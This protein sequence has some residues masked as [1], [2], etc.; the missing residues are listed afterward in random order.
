MIILGAGAAG[1]FAGAHSSVKTLILEKKNIAGN[2]LLIA[3]QGRCNFTHSGYVSAFFSHYGQNENFIKQV[4]KKYT[5]QD[6]ILFFEKKGLLITEDKNGKLFPESGN[7]RDILNI[8][9]TECKKKGNNIHFNE[10]VV[11]LSFQD[12][13]FLV[14]TKINNYSCKKLLVATGGK[15]YPSTGSAGDGYSFAEIFGH[16]INVPKPALSPVFI[17]NYQYKELAGVS[18]KD[19]SINLYRDDKRIF[20]HSGDI[21][22]THKGLSG[23]GI[24]DF[25]RYMDVNDIIKLNLCGI[26]VDEFSK[27]FLEEVKSNGKATIQVFLRQFEIPKA[28]LRLLLADLSIESSE[29]IGNITKEQRKNLVGKFCECPFEIE[30]IAGFNVAMCTAGGVSLNEINPKTMESKL[31]P[32]LF[33]AGEVLDIDGDTGGYNLQSAFS[34]GYLAAIS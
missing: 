12:G 6:L 10:P 26:S 16:H 9:L 15:S 32:G 25:S 29:K 20:S 33:F 19:C 7:A 5:N 17:K 4:L 14:N 28:L 24:L 1:L 3:G 8:L 11:N 13:V 31:Q 27:R 30:K 2:K 34:T 21:G 18:L 22:F 23:P